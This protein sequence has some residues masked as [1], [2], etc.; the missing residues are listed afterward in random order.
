MTI[1]PSNTWKFSRVKKEKKMDNTIHHNVHQTGWR[2]A[3]ARVPEGRSNL[4]WQESSGAICVWRSCDTKC[5]HKVSA[6]MPHCRFKFNMLNCKHLDFFSKNT[7]YGRGSHNPVL[8]VFRKSI[9]EIN[10]VHRGMLV[11][12]GLSIPRKRIR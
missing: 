2:F 4:G 3:G 6:K 1:L 10:S 9:T 12:H 7:I 8:T 11:R 5:A